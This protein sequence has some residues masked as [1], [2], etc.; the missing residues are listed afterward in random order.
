VRMLVDR[1]ELRRE[2]GAAGRRTVEERYSMRRSAALFADVVYTVVGQ[3]RTTEEVS[4]WEPKKSRN[5][6]R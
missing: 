4:Q 6:V 1:P 3:T 5:S 2:I